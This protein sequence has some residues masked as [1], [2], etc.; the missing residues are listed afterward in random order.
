VNDILKNIP[1]E[2]VIKVDPLIGFKDVDKA[3]DILL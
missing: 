3:I 1:K 2:R